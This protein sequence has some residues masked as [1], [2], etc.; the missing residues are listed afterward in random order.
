VDLYYPY[1]GF[2]IITMTWIENVGYCRPGE[3]GAFLR[4]HWDPVE[5]RVKVDGR[6]VFN[7]HGGALNEGATQSSGHVREAVYQL[8]GEAGPRQ[9]K[10]ARTALLTPGGWFHNATA[11]MLRAD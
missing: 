5:D 8:R 7:S 2:S 11:L 10:G 4:Q 6:V 1:D 3:G 9:V